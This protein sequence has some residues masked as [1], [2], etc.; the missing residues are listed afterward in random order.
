MIF[1][2]R[3]AICFFLLVT[4]LAHGQV[5]V[6][7]PSA[8]LGKDSIANCDRY[9]ASPQDETRPAEI[10][11]VPFTE[12][13]V[14]RAIAE[15]KEAVENIKHWPPQKA[16]RIWYQY[17]RALDAGKRYAESSAFYEL[18]SNQDHILAK[19]N[20]AVHFNLGLGG[21]N[22]NP[23][24]AFV[25][26]RDAA[27]HG[28]AISMHNLAFYYQT[29]RGTEKDPQRAL[30]WFRNAA[31]NGYLPAHRDLAQMLSTGEGISAPDWNAAAHHWR[32]L[33]E[34]GDA[35]ANWQIAEAIRRGDIESRRTNERLDALRRAERSDHRAAAY[36][37]AKLYKNGKEVVADSTKAARYAYRA[38]DL[39][40]NAKPDEEASWLLYER[41]AAR[42]LLALDDENLLEPRN[43]HEIRNLRGDFGD[44]K[45]KRFE[46][47]FQCGDQ[48]IIDISIYVWNWEREY[49]PTDPQFDFAKQVNGCKI[50]ENASDSFQRL[51]QLARKNDVSF[52]D[53]TVYALAQAENTNNH[54]PSTD[55][56]RAR[57]K[58]QEPPPDTSAAAPSAS[59]T[60]DS[61]LRVTAEG[62]VHLNHPT[63]LRAHI[64]FD[65][66]FQCGE[67]TITKTF[68]VHHVTGKQEWNNLDRRIYAALLQDTP[69]DL[70]N[71]LD[72]LKLPFVNKMKQFYEQYFSNL[73]ASV[74]LTDSIDMPIYNKT[75]PKVEFLY[76]CHMKIKEGYGN[77]MTAFVS[78]SESSINFM[79]ENRL[80]NGKIVSGNNFKNYYPFVKD[81]LYNIM[82]KINRLRAQCA[83]EGAKS[84]DISEIL[85]HEAKLAKWT[86]KISEG[87]KQAKIIKD[88]YYQDIGVGSSA[89]TSNQNE[90]L[91]YFC[92]GIG[93]SAY[94]MI[95]NINFNIGER[96]DI[97][98]SLGRKYYNNVQSIDSKYYTHTKYK[99]SALYKNNGDS[100][101]DDIKYATEI[102]FAVKGREISFSSRGSNKAIEMAQKICS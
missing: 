81:H 62:I 77:N 46:V 74:G 91:M 56:P 98:L 38:Y 31:E 68:R 23:N 97:S 25:L 10:K 102:I 6:H 65:L 4:T 27:Q 42:I 1:N 78:S 83:I 66:D 55:T 58:Q 18:A 34:A 54:S 21:R 92:D 71:N 93:S 22:E 95:S 9:A 67:E 76:S 11:G 19:N 5:Q 47:P 86:V 70:K 41:A 24:R 69:C 63:S 3:A 57:Q 12:I 53:L 17:A 15:C 72:K 99:M 28:V 44:G 14:K 20:L 100:L 33:A 61:P 39:S 16:A 49:T 48:G 8:A 96:K 45:M 7:G 73:Y 60:V 90:L 2:V 88:W 59:A 26:T 52:K 29:G 101:I 94:I 51:F 87:S 64:D 82:Y 75:L 84:I 50:P 85:L 30:H 37:L 89:F 35:D 79:R 40:R 36:A 43:I 32:V 80:L 13:S